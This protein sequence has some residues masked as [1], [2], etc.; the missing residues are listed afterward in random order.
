MKT[1]ERSKLIAKAFVLEWITV[2]WMTIEG[3]VAIWSGIRAHSLT[4]VAFG[5]D[6]AIEL[7]SA[8]V[9]LWR[10]TVELNH[11]E[12]FPEEV[13]RRASRVGGALL[14]LLAFYIVASACWSLWMHQGGEFSSLGLGLALV[15]IPVMFYLSRAKLKIAEEINSRAL[16]ADAMESITCGYLSFVVVIGLGVEYVFHAWWVD[17]VVSLGLVYFLLKEGLEAWRGEECCKVDC[18]KD[19]SQARRS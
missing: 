10:L 9:L 13:E 4:L 14:F 7:L 6:S 2:A 19:T 3:A 15:A 18:S 8:C 17:G 16:R 12:A 5:A 1:D 11:A